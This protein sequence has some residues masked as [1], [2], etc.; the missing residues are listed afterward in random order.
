[1]TNSSLTYRVLLGNPWLIAAIIGNMAIQFFFIYTPAVNT[2]WGMEPIA[3]AQWGKILLLAFGI[4]LIVEIEKAL[5][6]RVI[7][8]C[9]KALAPVGNALACRC[10]CCHTVAMR[11]LCPSA[12]TAA[13]GTPVPSLAVSNPPTTVDVG[14]A[15]AGA[16]AAKVSLAAT[17]AGTGTVSSAYA[18]ELALSREVRSSRHIRHAVVP[19]DPAVARAITLTKSN[20]NLVLPA[21]AVA[22]PG[23]AAGGHAMPASALAAG[24]ATTAPAP[25]TVH[26]ESA[27]S[28][29]SSGAG[30]ATGGHHLSPIP[31]GG[32]SPLLAATATA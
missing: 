16:G 24:P 29:S 7:A 12:S 30:A 2:V 19:S 31:E 10:A 9:I 4:F 25:F 13:T 14:T 27:S 1:M 20:K 23:G 18:R 15:A 11:V 6:P 3:G 28:A 17:G 8:P 22:A 32:K 21:A 26:V 5:W